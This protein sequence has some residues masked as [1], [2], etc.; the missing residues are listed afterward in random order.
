[1]RQKFLSQLFSL[2]ISNCKCDHDVKTI[3]WSFLPVYDIENGH[4]PPPPIQ[5]QPNQLFFL[6]IFYT[7]SLILMPKFCHWI[8]AIQVFSPNVGHSNFEQLLEPPHALE[9][10]CQCQYQSYV[11]TPSYRVSQKYMPHPTV[12]QINKCSAMNIFG[13]TFLLLSNL[14]YY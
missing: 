10:E 1:M 3:F 6:Y 4:S 7:C 12:G 14:I 5:F 11:T 2:P 13:S 9:A 8:C